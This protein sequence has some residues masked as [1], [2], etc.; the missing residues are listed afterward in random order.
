MQATPSAHW[1]RRW[2]WLRSCSTSD[3]SNYNRSKKRTSMSQYILAYD[4][5]CGPCTRFKESVD[6][7]DT[8]RR[9]RFVSLEEADSGGILDRVP[10]EVRHRSF[11]LVAP[12]GAVLSGAYAIPTLV[13]LL[14]TGGFASRLMASAPGGLRTVMFV[15]QTFSRLHDAGSCNYEPGTGPSSGELKR[16]HGND[17]ASTRHQGLLGELGV[18]AGVLQS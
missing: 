7:L 16:L 17:E 3:E 1:G 4:A 18:K 5:D 15:Y 10:Q 6:F 2:S 8:H 11:H 12:D 14:P 13:S 9:L